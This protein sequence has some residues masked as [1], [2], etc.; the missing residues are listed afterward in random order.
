MKRLRFFGVGILVVLL[1]AVMAMNINLKHNATADSQDLILN[2]IEALAQG[3][4]AE[5]DCAG[6]GSLVCGDKLFKVR[7]SR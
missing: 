7:V 6:S 3:E 1:V 2:N 4:G 5:Q